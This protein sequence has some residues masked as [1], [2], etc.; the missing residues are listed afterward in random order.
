MR[1][2]DIE[3]IS[4]NVWHVSDND[5]HELSTS[6]YG[7][8][9]SNDVYIIRWRYKII[10]TEKKTDIT[11]DRVAYWIWQGY[12]ANPNEQGIS[13]LMSMFV[14]EEKGPHVNKIL[15]LFVKIT[16]FFFVIDSCYSR[17]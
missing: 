7:Q 17:T 3:T 8:F 2:H 14:N 16:L 1:G 10:S 15:I 5:R 9:Y 6:S 11:R 13:S 4:L 12:N